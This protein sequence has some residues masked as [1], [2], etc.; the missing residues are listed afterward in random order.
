MICLLTTLYD[1]NVPF[2]LVSL[3]L[4]TFN[5]SLA[6]SYWFPNGRGGE[7][8]EGDLMALPERRNATGAQLSL[9]F[10]VPRN[11]VETL[12]ML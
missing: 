7:D 9:V 6:F 12:R 11:V 3:I 8:R 1:P 10:L 5:S 2:Q 4:P